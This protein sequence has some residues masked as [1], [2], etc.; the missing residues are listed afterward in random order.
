MLKK[1]LIIKNKFARK[2]F[3]ISLIF[4]CIN[5]ISCNKAD[6]SEKKYSMAVQY[7]LTK[8]FQNSLLLIEQIKKNDSYYYLSLFLKAKI[9]FFKNDYHSSYSLCKLILKKNQNFIEA[10]LLLIRNLIYL[11]LFS[12]AERILKTEMQ[13][14]STDWRI[15]YLYSLLFKKKN[16]LDCQLEMLDKAESCIKKSQII[17]DNYSSIWNQLELY[18]KAVE[19]QVKKNILINK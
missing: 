11:E 12:E 17:Y 3:Q 1:Y 18:D 16:L 10:Q 19:Y 4:F 14:N 2:I 8:D 15:Y 9:L 7:Y 6:E 5:L 13:I